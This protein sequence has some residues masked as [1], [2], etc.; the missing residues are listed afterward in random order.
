MKKNL[1]SLQK[2]FLDLWFGMFIHFN[3]ATFQFNTG[4]IMDWEYDCENGGAERKYPFNPIDWNP[5]E[6]DCRQWAQAAKSAGVRFAALTTKHHEGFC[7]WPSEYT[8][9]CI[10]NS[11]I[12][13]DVVA[14][15]LSAF[16]DEGISAGLYFSVLD[17]TNGI[18]RTQFTSEGRDLVK[19][20]LT[21]LLT[22]YGEI[23]FIIIDG[24]NAPWGGP[25]WEELPFEELDELIKGIQPNCLLMN[26]GETEDISKTDI[27]FFENAAGQEVPVDFYGPGV[28]CNILTKTWFWRSSDPTSE[29]KSAQ[30]AI[31]TV[32]FMNNQN[33]AFIIN[34]S[35]NTSGLIDKNLLDKYEEIGKDLKIR[36]PLEKIS[37]GWLKR[38]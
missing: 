2:D 38:K 20:Q 16:R 3:S 15:Y 18:N 22:N 12:K 36:Q 11:P 37:E 6:L 30:W 25:S 9:H 35:P 27:V 23:P 33:V 10:K 1:V 17:L 8:E 21:E 32:N 14:E 26:I 28:S 29:L 7:L 31:D 24:W 13:T 4:D 5:T 34:A 19:Q